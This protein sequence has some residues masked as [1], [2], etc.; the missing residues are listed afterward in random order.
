MLFQGGEE[1][2]IEIG[3][4]L[5][6]LRTQAMFLLCAEKKLA[7][8]EKKM[9]CVIRCVQHVCMRLKKKTEKTMKKQ[10]LKQLQSGQKPTEGPQIPGL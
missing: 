3:V 2:S 5:L 8:R 6:S 7:V 1:V 10:A 9:L 4:R